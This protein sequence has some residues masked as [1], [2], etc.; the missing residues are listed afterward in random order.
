MRSLSIARS[1]T[2]GVG[3]SGV[4]R[5]VRVIGAYYQWQKW[6]GPVWER[7]S[8]GAHWDSY[9]GNAYNLIGG[10]GPFE[11]IDYAVAIGAE[12]VITTTETSSPEE[13]ADLVTD[14]LLS[15][16]AQLFLFVV[17]NCVYAG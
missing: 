1:S 5:T 16:C 3:S 12:P 9:G 8:I 13:F 11:M 17:D 4:T 6:T 15:L 7:P 14:P 10:W 2:A